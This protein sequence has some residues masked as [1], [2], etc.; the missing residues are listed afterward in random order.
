[1]LR[2]LASGAPVCVTVTIPDAIVLARAA[3]HMSV[4]YRSVVVLGRAQL[5]EGDEKA[6]GLQRIIEHTAPGRWDDIRRPSDKELKQ[7]YVLG[8]D[9]SEASAKVR[10][11][12]VLDEEEDYAMPVWAG[13]VPVALVPGAPIPDGRV[14]PGVLPPA[15][16]VDYRRP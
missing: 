10:A 7:T 13:M 5:V 4:D 11:A 9:V 14:Q 3:F 16:A 1:M 15:Y 6:L 8:M 2:T 12:G